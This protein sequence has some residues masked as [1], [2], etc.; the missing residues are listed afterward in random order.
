MEEVL[1]QEYQYKK[2]CQGK[3]CNPMDIYEPYYVKSTVHSKYL[4]IFNLFGRSNNFERF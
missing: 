3:Y 4:E 1:N 2:S